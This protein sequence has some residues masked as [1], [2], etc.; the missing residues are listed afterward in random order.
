MG[1]NEEIWL[2]NNVGASIKIDPYIHFYHAGIP[3]PLD[4]AWMGTDSS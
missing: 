2:Q 3:P 4:R 1:S